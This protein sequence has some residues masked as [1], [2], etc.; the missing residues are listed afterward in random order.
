MGKSV[1]IK[2]L[3][4]S[5]ITH[6][7]IIQPISLRF[8]LLGNQA[9]IARTRQAWGWSISF[10]A[11][12]GRRQRQPGEPQ[13]QW[14]VLLGATSPVP[15]SLRTARL[16]VTQA[17]SAH[18]PPQRVKPTPESRVQFQRLCLQAWLTRCLRRS[19]AP[20]KRQVPK[21]A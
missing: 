18:S 2:A 21:H 3:S 7:L 17:N 11:E 8:I 13:K 20:E 14:P 4:D 16:Q 19:Q 9:W 10:Q 1:S 6:R 5:H 15:T 12:Q